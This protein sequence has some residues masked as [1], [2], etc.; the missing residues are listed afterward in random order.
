MSVR[1]TPRDDS[2]LLDLKVQG[3]VLA[4]DLRAW[5]PSSAAVRVRLLGLVRSGYIEVVGRHGGQRI[6]AL[7]PRGK[8]HLGIRSSWRTRPQEAFRQVIWRRCHARLVAEGYYRAGPWRGGLVLYR[9]TTGPALAVQVFATGPS[10]RHLRA[11]FKKIRP[12]LIRDGALLC[13]FSAEAPALQRSLA[14]SSLLLC[15]QLPTVTR[16]GDR[17]GFRPGQ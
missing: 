11:L 16:A 7:G 13:V 2:L 14:C 10:T 12:A 15:R 5:F 1:L 6:F 3:A 4:D 17:S 9:G 8:R